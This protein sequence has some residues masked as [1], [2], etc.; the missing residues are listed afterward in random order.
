MGGERL[1]GEL[2]GGYFVAPTVFGDV[3]NSA[4]IAQEELFGPVLSIIRFDDEEEAIRLANDT[5]YGLAAYLHT[6]DVGRAHRVAAQLEAG[7]IGVNGGIAPAGFRAPFGG[8][9]DS[10]YGRQGGQ[11]GIWEFLRLKNVMID[12]ELVRHEELLASRSPRITREVPS[13]I[14]ANAEQTF[15][16][17]LDFDLWTVLGSR[18]LL[19][20]GVSEM[21]FGQQA[22]PP[23]SS[24]QVRELLTL[25]A[26]AGHRDFRD[27]RGPM[28]FTQRQAAG[29]FTREEAEAF[30]DRLHDPDPGR[31]AEAPVWRH[32]AQEQ[33]LRRIPAELLA[34]ELRRR[35]W[36]VT[37]P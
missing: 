26:R 9:K 23:A 30:I 37:E 11:H 3:D 17:R 10:G 27:A 25:L 34:V 18:L 36:G 14:E 29:R 20:G 16:P 8:V 24:R 7:S 4:P 13:K 6:R 35:G 21:A 2:T 22:G 31:P 5:K 33:L 1:K 12:R 15:A 19:T 28:G 32:S